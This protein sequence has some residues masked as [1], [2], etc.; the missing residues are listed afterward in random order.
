MRDDVFNLTP[1]VRTGIKC[2]AATSY[3]RLFEIEANPTTTGS[4]AAHLI[5][6]HLGG[7]SPLIFVFVGTQD[8]LGCFV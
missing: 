8:N 6:P 7:K 4:S 3:A 1:S 2:C 5:E